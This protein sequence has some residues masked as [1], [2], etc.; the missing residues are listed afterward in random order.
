VADDEVVEQVDVE[1]AACSQR[2][3]GEVQVVGRWRR[4]AARMVVDEDH[5]RGIKADGV[6]KQLADPDERGA[7]V[8]LVGRGQQRDR[9]VWWR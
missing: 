4:I 3:G 1:E 5:S 9:P 7:Y 8:A 6:A 2:L